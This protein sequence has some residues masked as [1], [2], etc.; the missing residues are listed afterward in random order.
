MTPE[1]TQQL[2]ASLLMA[3]HSGT[4]RTTTRPLIFIVV[5]SLAPAGH[6]HLA[7]FPV[8]PF[9][10]GEGP[11]GIPWYFAGVPGWDSWGYPG[12]HP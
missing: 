9:T 3:L 4:T 6:V 5:V 7:M 8:A 11:S 12:I 2:H 10:R 1:K